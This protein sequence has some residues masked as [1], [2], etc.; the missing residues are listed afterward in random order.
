MS[1]QIDLKDAK[2]GM[3]VEFDSIEH[4]EP[5]GRVPEGHF[6]GNLLDI[7]K[8]TDMTFLSYLIQDHRTFGVLGS[9]V[10][11]D[12]DDTVFAL[13]WVCD[14]EVKPREYVRNIRLYESK[15]EAATEDDGERI[16]DITKVMVKDTV[17]LKSGNRYTAVDV[18]PYCENGHTLY[19]RAEEFGV[20][21][22][23]WAYDEDF[24][25]AVHR[26]FDKFGWPLRTGFYKDNAKQVWHFD[27]KQN[28]LM[29][30]FTDDGSPAQSTQSPVYGYGRFKRLAD[31]QNLWPL[32]ETSL[33]EAS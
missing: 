29:R 30:V 3:W 23:W 21:G 26:T 13:F 11:P 6:A 4:D 24:Q 14:G 7:S 27:A 20:L 10:F 15:P 1:K 28:N 22:G 2:E 12:T 32:A 5:N 16:T 19:L 17:V 18:R 33:V 9:V 8:S 31:E 25:Y